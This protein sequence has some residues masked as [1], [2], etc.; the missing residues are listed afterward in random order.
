MASIIPYC[1]LK[2]AAYCLAVRPNLWDYVIT[3][4]MP[5]YSS[6]K[7]HTHT[8]THKPMCALCVKHVLIDKEGLIIISVCGDV[9]KCQ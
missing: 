4:L 3:A 2:S 6:Y 8:H 1:Q 7:T 5:E 9:L